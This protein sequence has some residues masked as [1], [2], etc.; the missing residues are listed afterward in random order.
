MRIIL[1]LVLS[2]FITS[3]CAQERK[4]V[5]GVNLSGVASQVFGDLVGGFH[6]PGLGLSLSNTVRL[7]E[8]KKFRFELGYIQKGSLQWGNANTGT[9]FYSLSAHYVEVPFI[10]QIDIFKGAVE[11]GLNLSKN[12]RLV[13][14]DLYGVFPSYSDANFAELGLLFGYQQ[15]LSENWYVNY[16]YGN[17]ITPMRPHQSKEI[18]WNNWGQ[19][20][21]Y[22][23]VQINYNFQ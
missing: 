18:R 23:Q 16:R 17:S 20:H 9:Q 2:F 3:L 4:F 1:I 6:R 19:M 10:W 22:F 14:K 8:G 12:I 7:S 13:E 5:L 15:R 21:S 11:L